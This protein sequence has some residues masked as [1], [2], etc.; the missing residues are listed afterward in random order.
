MLELGTGTVIVWKG[1]VM[2]S[3]NSVSNHF[4]AHV[5]AV[6]EEVFGVWPLFWKVVSS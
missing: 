6:W 1:G 2:S 5:H 4:C 3:V